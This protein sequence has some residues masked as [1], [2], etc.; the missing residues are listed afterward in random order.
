MRSVL[1]AFVLRASA[2]P[3]SV[4][5]PAL[6][7]GGVLLGGCDE[8]RRDEP[9]PPAGGE[10][11]G[12]GVYGSPAHDALLE[13]TIEERPALN[14]P[15]VEAW[16]DTPIASALA[17]RLERAARADP[18]RIPGPARIVL[19]N[20]V[21]GLWQRV[22]AVPRSS[23]NRT[24]LAARAAALVHRLAFDGP[25]EPPS[26]IPAPIAPVLAGYVER[27]SELPSLQHE[28]L[29]GL[30]RIFHV[31]LRGTNERALF[32]S[33]V[34]LDGRGRPRRTA[35]VGDLE[36]LAFEG[37]RLVRA[38]L[39]ELDRR[40]LRCEGPSRALREVDRAAH[41]PGTGANGHLARF[42]PPVP[43]VD[44]PCVRCHDDAMEMSLPHRG[45]TVGARHRALLEQ[46]AEAAPP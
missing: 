41:V 31:A 35:I 1:R 30:R 3:A 23:E 33:L 17:D 32:S 45:W 39:F 38:R 4:L 34:A 14:D 6:L 40:R 44:L 2:L 12:P 25:D 28:R 20:D 26:A 18:S 8:P 9:A 19:Q 7:A 11:C 29:F 5:A 10:S 43:L 13:P 15:F 22:T 21:W 27:E 46:A 37:E 16:I 42:D 36:M 24:R